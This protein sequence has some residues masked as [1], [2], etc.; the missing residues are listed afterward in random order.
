MVSQGSVAHDPARRRDVPSPPQSGAEVYLKLDF[1]A[2]DHPVTP[3]DGVT[4]ELAEREQALSGRSLRLAHQDSGQPLGARAPLEVTGAAGLR[5]A[6]A[7]RARAMQSVTVNVFDE[8]RQDNT[9]PMSPARV[10]DDDWHAAVLAVEGFRYNGGPPDSPIGPDTQ[11]S[12]LFF[13]GREDGPDAELSIDKLVVYRGHDAAP[14]EAPAGLRGATGAD[15]TVGLTWQEPADNIFA[16]VYSIY[17]KAAAGTW[18]KIGETLRPAFED[19]SPTATSVTYRVTAADFD[20]NV[21]PPS[22]EATVNAAPVLRAGGAAAE[23][24]I[25]E[26]DRLNYAENVRLVHA[27]GEGKV[28]PDVFLFAGDSITAATVYTHTL[29]SW[30]G[31]GLAVRQGVGQVTTD[32]GAANIR[33]YLTEA[34]P[35]FAIVM[36]G[37]N[38]LEYGRSVS[39]AMRQLALIVDACVE[40][41]TIP[42]LATI[43]PR[44]FDKRR[45]SG[46][47]EFN[48]A[49]AALA[50]QKRVPVSYVF[51]EMMRHDLEAMLY[52][53]VH[54]QPESGNDAAGRALRQT[55]DRVYF[56]L[57]DT[58]VLW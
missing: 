3:A 45:Q 43:P 9:T 19:R 20:N 23:E 22:S 44:G 34:R 16:V 7:F 58:S 21:S 38:D 25:W 57:R 54:L 41:G 24:S 40:A 5:V 52:D 12:S 2:G 55:M 31:R 14:P 35:E 50:R 13:H 47:E 53:G 48:R 1:D 27:R 26:A 37:T 10:F 29:G 36:Y 51:Q 11:F 56:A 6:F 4:I 18:E 32:Y 46:P 30:L 8:R 39:A 15:R 33:Q 49:L 28:R 42:V 17:R